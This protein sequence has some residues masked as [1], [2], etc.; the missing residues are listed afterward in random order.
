MYNE[1][2]YHNFDDQSLLTMNEKI[3]LISAAKLLKN[4]SNLTQITKLSKNKI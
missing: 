2:D 3:S 1:E 4:P